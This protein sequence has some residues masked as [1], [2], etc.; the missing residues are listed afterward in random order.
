MQCVL[1]PLL[2]ADAETDTWGNDQLSVSMS[3]AAEQTVHKHEHDQ[4]HEQETNE[5][6]RTDR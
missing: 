4:E 6:S 1:P 2:T 5:S 3:E